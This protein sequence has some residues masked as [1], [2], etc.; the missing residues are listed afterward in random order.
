MVTATIAVS[1]VM[2]IIITE[3]ERDLTQVH[4]MYTEHNR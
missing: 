3:T 4:T 1:N 2:I